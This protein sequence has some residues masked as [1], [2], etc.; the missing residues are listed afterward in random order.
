MNETIKAL[1]NKAASSHV[2]AETSW[3][4]QQNFLNRFAEL[5]VSDCAKCVEHIDVQGGGNLGDV[6]KNKFG[7]E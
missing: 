7:L 1:W 4:T 2:Q 6:I 3:Q 5:I